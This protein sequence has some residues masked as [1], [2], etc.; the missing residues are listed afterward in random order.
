MTSLNIFIILGAYITYSTCV[1]ATPVETQSSE[2]NFETCRQKIYVHLDAAQSCI[3]NLFSPEEMNETR[4]I[5]V[6]TKCPECHL[7][8]RKE[9]DIVDCIKDAAD[10]LKIFSNKSREMV[11][12]IAQFAEEALSAY[13]ENENELMTVFGDMDNRECYRSGRV[14]CRS[15][16]EFLDHLDRTVMCESLHSGNDTLNQKTF[17]QHFDDF[18]GCADKGSTT[19]SV[20]IR[21]HSSNL[22]SKLRNS[23]SCSKYYQ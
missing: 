23:K 19:C 9:N 21:N 16:L 18:L 5:H 3:S 7:F 12:F 10:H 1:L 6:G 13:S 22:I 14:A 20:D 17:C 4:R 8:L 2:E 15:H 11:P